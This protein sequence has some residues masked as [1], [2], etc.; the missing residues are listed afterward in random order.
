MEDYYGYAW[1]M[2]HWFN[3]PFIAMPKRDV[4][5]DNRWKKPDWSAY[6]TTSRMRL[7]DGIPYRLSLKFDME[8]W[9]AEPNTEVSQAD[10][11]LWYARPGG[12]SNRVP[13]PEEAVRDL[14]P[15]NGKQLITEPL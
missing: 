12:T 3:S 1:G 15:W 8:L 6:T 10:G 13:Q 2:A 7:L 14:I 11:V 9:H 5:Y 4:T